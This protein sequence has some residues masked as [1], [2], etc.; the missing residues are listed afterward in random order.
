M[1]AGRRG[2]GHGRSEGQGGARQISIARLA[3]SGGYKRERKM[4]AKGNGAK[5]V[6]LSVS[7]GINARDFLRCGLLDAL[8]DHH[9]VIV[10]QLAKLESFVQEFSADNI[11]VLVPPDMNPRITRIGTLKHTSSVSLR[12]TLIGLSRRPINQ[13]AP[14]L[15]GLWRLLVR[16]FFKDRSYYQYFREIPPDVV[17]IPTPRKNN[18]ADISISLAAQIMG[19]P[20]VSIVSSWDNPQKG[21]FRT[22]PDRITAWSDVMAEEL[23]KYQHY[24]PG[25][26]TITGALQFDPYFNN[27][28]IAT[29]EDFCKKLNIDPNKRILLVATAGAFFN[30]QTFIVDDIIS[31]IEGH[32]LEHDVQII[33]RVHF[34]DKSEFF[35]AYESRTDFILD[36]SEE[37]YKILGT[38]GWTMTL[39]NIHH[40]ANLLHH[41]DLVI[42]MASTI[43]LEAAIYDT[44]TIVVGYYPHDPER[45]Q[46]IYYEFAFKQHYKPLIDNDL[47]NIVNN[48]AEMI[49]QIN[50]YLEDPGQD[51]KKRLEMVRMIVQQ[52]DGQSSNRVAQFI[53][54]NAN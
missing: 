4:S 7:S 35:F 36:R 12:N 41:S 39:N 54:A 2:K 33:V 22:Y 49:D 23:V 53:L 44:P 5:C 21:I 30:D 9:V 17:V 20:T 24:R 52:T 29:R 42:N 14:F 1:A 11:T 34:T 51:A 18:P 46:K 19:I 28:P 38:F 15:N 6:Y 8:R 48:K 25:K 50:R 27:P 31:A 10:S 47:L 32:E 16:P 13:Y 43:T 37:W 40:L 3:K 26:V 45:L